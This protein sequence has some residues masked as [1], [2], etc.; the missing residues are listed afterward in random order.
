MWAMADIDG[1]DLVKHFY[2]SMFSSDSRWEGVPHYKRTA[3]A[4]QDAVRRLR[5]NLKRKITL[6]RWVNFVHYGA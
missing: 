5:R 4:L 3:E 2:R 6:E 1:P